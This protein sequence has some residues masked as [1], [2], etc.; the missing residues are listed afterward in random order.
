MKRTLALCS[1]PLISV[2]DLPEDLVAHSGM[3]ADGNPGGF[4][5]QRSRRLVAFE[6]EFL[7]DLLLNFQGDVTACARAAQLPRGTLYRL[8]KKHG[9]TPNGFRVGAGAM[10]S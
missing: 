2:D 7:R 9:L 6:K 8:L 4:F 5:A 10:T 3:P 1:Q